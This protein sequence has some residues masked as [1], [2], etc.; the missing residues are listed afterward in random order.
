MDRL[1]VYPFG[2]PVGVVRSPATSPRRVFILGVYPSAFH[3]SWFSPDGRLVS[4]ALAVADEPEPFWDG[5]GGAGVLQRVAE[6]VPAEAGALRDAGE[7]NG[8]AGRTLAS[9]YLQPLG[10]ER[11]EVWIA[12]LQNYYLASDGQVRRIEESYEPLVATG[13][14]PAAALVPRASRST[15]DRLAEDRDPPLA[16]EWA[17]AEPEWL[18]TLGDEPVKVLGLED[19]REGEYGQPRQASV[20]GRDVSHLALVHT[21]QAGK[22]GS[23][24]PK[25]YARHHGWLEQLRELRPGWLD[26]LAG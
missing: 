22:H 26:E 11:S 24:S 20:F 18:I 1:G 3:A 9:A 7:H 16:A 19:L 5:S 21:R 15:I 23:H 4:P 12:D 25:W 17:E 10:L 13:V 6:R 14:V 2:E 8:R